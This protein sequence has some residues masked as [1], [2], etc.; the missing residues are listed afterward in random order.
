MNRVLRTSLVAAA[1]ALATA[2]V[3]GTR[4][5]SV[6][7]VDTTLRYAYG[8][9]GSARSSLD[10]NQYLG[11]QVYVPTGATA[12][13]V[14]CFA[15]N[16]AGTPGSC[17]STN[18]AAVAAAQSINPDSYVWFQWDTSGNCT[19]LNVRACSYDAPKQP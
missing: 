7:I 11:C 5:G 2:A 15:R 10:A 9:M 19:Y 14:T 12:A 6:V 3:A 17:T 18:P 8:A 1:L 13:R 4:Y 16:A